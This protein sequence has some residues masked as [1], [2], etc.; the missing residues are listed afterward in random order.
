MRI[1]SSIEVGTDVCG[2]YYE[3]GLNISHIKNGPDSITT[4][5]DKSLHF[6]DSIHHI[7][8]VYSGEKLLVE[9]INFPV[10]VN[11]VEATK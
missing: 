9:I 4:I 2:H 7:Y 6:P 10:V 5:I 11:Y 3:V 1:I 8:A